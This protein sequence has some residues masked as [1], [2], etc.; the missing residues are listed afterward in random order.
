M[1]LF[2][3]ISDKESIRFETTSDIET[4]EIAY[5]RRGVSFEFGGILSKNQVKDFI[6]EH[7]INVE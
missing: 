7:G 3:E 2:N 4:S 1:K 5:R 6:K